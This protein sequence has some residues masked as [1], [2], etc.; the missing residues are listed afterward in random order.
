VTFE[1]LLLAYL[2]ADEAPASKH[3]TRI[4]EDS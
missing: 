3:L 1:E 2:G 4:G